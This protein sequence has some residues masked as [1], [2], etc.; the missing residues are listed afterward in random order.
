LAT[1]DVD[2]TIFLTSTLYRGM[3]ITNFD[4]KQ[5]IWLQLNWALVPICAIRLS[6]PIQAQ[7]MA[8]NDQYIQILKNNSKI[9]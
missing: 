5:K 2:V 3:G 9:A 8:Q 6:I 4:L 7:N 1:H